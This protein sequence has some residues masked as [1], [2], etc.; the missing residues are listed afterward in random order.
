M[1]DGKNTTDSKPGTEHSAKITKAKPQSQKWGGTTLH[2]HGDFTGHDFTVEGKQNTQQLDDAA[3]SSKGLKILSDAAHAIHR[4]K[5][6]KIIT[7]ARPRYHPASLFNAPGPDYCPSDETG[8]IL[9]GNP[10]LLRFDLDAM[11]NPKLDAAFKLLGITE[12]CK[13]MYGA[14]SCHGFTVEG[15]RNIQKLVDAGVEFEGSKA[16]KNRSQSPRGR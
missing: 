15:K 12:R 10:A 11:D 3:D 7:D 6:A 2:S 13:G 4:E 14:D 9:M 8:S 1:E 5:A 16:F